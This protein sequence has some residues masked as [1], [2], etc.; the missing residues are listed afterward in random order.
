MVARLRPAHNPAVNPSCQDFDWIYKQLPASFRGV[1]FAVRADVHESGRRV[2]IHEYINR[3]DWDTEDLGRRASIVEVQAFV[4][5]PDAK[6]R[7]NALLE[8]C[9]NPNSEG[10]LVLPFRRPS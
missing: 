4:F 1:S 9:G 5:G 2:A 3:N 8:A 7:S 6:I 10:T